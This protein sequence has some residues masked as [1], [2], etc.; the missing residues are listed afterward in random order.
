MCLASI[1][2]RGGGVKRLQE[3]VCHKVENDDFQHEVVKFI[4][5][6]ED[7]DALSLA[8]LEAIH[9]AICIYRGFF[10]GLG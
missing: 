4:L 5:E 9:R 2:K 10:T 8:I 1:F 3:S 7:I 6:T